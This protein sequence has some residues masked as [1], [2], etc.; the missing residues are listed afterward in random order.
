MRIDVWHRGM[1]QRSPGYARAVAELEGDE[2]QRIADEILALRMEAGLTQ[3]EVAKLAKTTQAEVS[4]LERAE[5][6]PKLGTIG[7]VIRALEGHLA[8]GA[9]SLVSIVTAEHT[10]SWSVALSPGGASDV[11][12]P[13]GSAPA[14]SEPVSVNYIA[15]EAPPSLA[16]STAA[17]ADHAK[18]A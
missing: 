11:I 12:I 18:A 14:V 16:F 3:A 7:K 17:N 5:G 15:T 4:R 13:Q 1:L 10:P 9:A 6:N 2:F 8:A